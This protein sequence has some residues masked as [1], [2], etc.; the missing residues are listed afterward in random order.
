MLKLR[1]LILYFNKNYLI[2]LL[3][4]I[5]ITSLYFIEINDFI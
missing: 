5:I 3:F 4:E 2:Y 1:L